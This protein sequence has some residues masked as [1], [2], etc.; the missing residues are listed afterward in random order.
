MIPFFDD[1]F[2]AV[3][4]SK[5]G[6][7][8]VGDKFFNKK[9]NALVEASKTQQPIGWEFH[10]DVFQE[11][12]LKP[13]LDVSLL[14]LY[15]Q[16]ALQLREQYDYL[17]LAYSGGADSDNMLRAFIDNNIKL[18]EVWCDQP[19]MLF[20][21]AGYQVSYSTDATNMPAEW[22]LVIKPELEKLAITNPEI[23]IHISDSFSLLKDDDEEDT[24]SFISVPT[25]YTTIRRYR[26]L[27]DYVQTFKD[28]GISTSVVVG[29]DKCIPIIVQ[30]QYGF[31]LADTPT[32][33]KT[34]ITTSYSIH[35]EYFY[36]TPD[37]PSIVVEQARRLWDHFLKTPESTDHIVNV[38][39]QR[40]TKS[41]A[42]M[43]RRNYLDDTIA[44]ICYPHWNLNKLQV[45]K[46]GHC[47]YNMQYAKYLNKFPNETFVQG[48]SFNTWEA[49]KNLNPHFCFE[50]RRD[51]G[52]DT[53]RFLKF[54]MM[55]DI[56]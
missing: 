37:M 8:T 26:Y 13:R 36:W 14:E 17:I 40:G 5:Q 19:L 24:S 53:K 32:Y 16:R 21:K 25:V 7:Y 28:R 10:T 41:K 42:W 18:D 22:F 11:Q 27:V 35:V 50:N 55:G 47:I 33:L 2:M 43:R 54:F 49:I 44:T 30:N 29:M 51:L 38:F 31:V 9:M 3:N 15:K 12:L 48:F 52:D 39:K 56:K 34:H 46:T 6:Y 4:A 1:S 45:D 20:D 23:K